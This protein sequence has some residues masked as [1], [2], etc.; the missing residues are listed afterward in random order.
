VRR[1][2]R[3]IRDVIASG[4]SSASDEAHATSAPSSCKGV[5]GAR[6][7]SCGGVT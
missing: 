5:V 1:T 6:T 2:G 4:E 3:I 7:R